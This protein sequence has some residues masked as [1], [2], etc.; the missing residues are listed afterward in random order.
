MP[1]VK[2]ILVMA[3]IA[4]VAVSVARHVS[5]MNVPVVS[6]LLKAGGY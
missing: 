2:Q 5:G 3:A 6:G 1:S 4:L